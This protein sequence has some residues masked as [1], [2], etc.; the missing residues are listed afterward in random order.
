MGGCRFGERPG[1]AR[2]RQGG[3]TSPVSGVVNP[4]RCGTWVLRRLFLVSPLCEDAFFASFSF[5]FPFVLS[6]GRDFN[7]YHRLVG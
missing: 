3:G 5:L 6:F 2:K 1:A 4:G 7:I